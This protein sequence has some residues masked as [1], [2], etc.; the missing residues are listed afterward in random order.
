MESLMNPRPSPDTPQQPQGVTLEY[1]L[2]IRIGL[3][4]IKGNSKEL[5][6]ARKKLEII[7]CN[8]ISG[9][10]PIVPEPSKDNL[11]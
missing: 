7:I 1:L 3:D 9:F 2:N 8:V 6:D 4:Q 10:T 11:Q 5:Q